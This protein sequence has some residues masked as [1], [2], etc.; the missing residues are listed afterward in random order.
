MNVL[1]NWFLVLAGLFISVVVLWNIAEWL[2]NDI[3]CLVVSSHC[4]ASLEIVDD[5][6]SRALGLSGR[7]YLASGS[8]MLFVFDSP[9]RQCFWMKDMKFPLDIVWLNSDKQVVYLQENVSPDSYPHNFCSDDL[10]QYVIEL[11]AGQA[12]EFGITLGQTLE[13]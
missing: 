3:D 8:G 10:A 13:F 2:Q 12:R 11:N 1:R 9:D 7:E 5:D 4:V 6:K